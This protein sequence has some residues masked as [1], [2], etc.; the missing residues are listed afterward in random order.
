MS[1]CVREIFILTVNPCCISFGSLFCFTI[2]SLDSA[3]NALVLLSW[4]SKIT[5]VCVPESAVVKILSEV[6]VICYSIVCAFH[7]NRMKRLQKCAY[8]YLETGKVREPQNCNAN[9]S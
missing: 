8:H 9:V 7:N 2:F 6:E 3:S 4:C 5:K 1:F